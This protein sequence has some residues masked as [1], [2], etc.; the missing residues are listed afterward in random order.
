MCNAVIL[1]H[2]AWSALPSGELPGRL[3][4]LVTDRVVQGIAT[5]ATVADALDLVDVIPTV[6]RAIVVLGAGPLPPDNPPQYVFT[7]PRSVPDLC[8]GLDLVVADPVGR[9]FGHPRRHDEGFRFTGPD[10]CMYYGSVREVDQYLRLVAGIL[11]QGMRGPEGL[12]VVGAVLRFSLEGG[13][14]PFVTLE[15]PCPET[16]ARLL[17][18]T[19]DLSE[20]EAPSQVTLTATGPET[21]SVTVIPPSPCDVG[22]AFQ[23][24]VARAAVRAHCRARVMGATAR[25]LVVLLREAVV[26]FADEGS[27]LQQILA[28]GLCAP[29]TEEPTAPAPRCSI[30]FTGDGPD[31]A[32]TFHF[33]VHAGGTG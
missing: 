26:L 12:F 18:G 21:L 31:C 15:A 19:A 9:A 7:G 24:F 8:S 22:T 32:P 28:Q 14:V 23:A 5:A 3:V 11:R 25:E 10:W 4:V 30:R 13:A 17:E 27:L 29:D 33:G 1:S 6:D 2:D 20:D 16:L